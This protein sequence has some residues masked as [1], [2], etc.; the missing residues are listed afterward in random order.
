MTRPVRRGNPTTPM[1]QSPGA[2]LETEEQFDENVF[3][4]L[5]E[6]AGR[7]RTLVALDSETTRIDP[8]RGF[9]PFYGPR[10][11]MGSISFEDGPTEHNYAFPLRMREALLSLPERPRKREQS[12]A[13]TSALKAWA[14]VKS[15]DQPGTFDNQL[16][17]DLGLEIEVETV[18]N[19]RPEFV[20]GRLNALTEAGVVWVMKNVK[21]DVLMY[22]ADGME[23]IPVDQLEEVEFQSHLTEDKPWQK[24]KRVSHKLQ[25][26][27]VRHLDRAPDASNALEEWFTRMRIAKEL[28]DYS[29]VPARSILAPYAWQDTRDT[30]DLLHFFDRK[31]RRMDE[32]SQP[33]KK[34]FDLYRREVRVLWHL[35]YETITEGLPVDQEKADEVYS[36]YE[37]D[38][39]EKT[40]QLERLTGGREIDWGSNDEV[41]SYLYDSPADG[42]LGIPVPEGGWTSGGESGQ[43]KR[44]V[45]AYVLDKIDHPIVEQ[46]VAW[47]KADH[48]MN[49]FLAPI[50]RFNVGGFVHP[51]FHLTS[52]RTGRMSASH[53]NMQNRP[54]DKD[55]REM[56]VARP[57]YVL[58]AKDYDQIEMRIAAHFAYLV[59]KH[60]PTFWYESRF[61]GRS[62]MMRSHQEEAPM[63][64]GFNS[65][66][67]YDPHMKMVELSG[68]PRKRTES[69]EAT[70]K[71]GNF[72]IL[73]GS[74][75]GGLCRNFGWTQQFSRRV[76]KYWREAWPEIQ[77]LMNFVT[78]TIIEKGYVTNEF[79][80]RYYIDPDKAY[81]GLNYLIQGCAGDLM[82]RGLEALF[83][84]RWE[85]REEYEGPQPIYIDNVVHD[86]VL[87]E[88][89]EDLCTP[90]LVGRI[91]D[92]LTTHV[93]DDGSQ[94][95]NLPITAGAEVGYDWGHLEEY[96][97]REAA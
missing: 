5:I 38:R 34:L 65:D 64:E 19:L 95:F 67:K 26:L 88:V 18:E 23:R 96:E 15:A 53:P 79:G 90:Q 82:K 62:R 44:S 52:V 2:L 66:P 71:E 14:G 87:I 46:F 31:M 27:A 9:N 92:A 21:F 11:A 75:I 60:F 1:P 76:K 40:R 86:E 32:S 22:S 25:E 57:G 74:G 37:A 50:A 81:L 7:G 89:R 77:H 24:G 12:K 55:I 56:F 51:D 6:L 45:A 97:F 84:L 17:R 30:L 49:S 10:V 72:S 36:K 13:Y 59:C 41:A 91:N 16:W 78:K 47:R 35:T 85:L 73:Y 69:G 70:A 93:R 20:I 48:F 83:A 80:R 43:Q 54:K 8:A 39:D 33:G 28:R 94:V 58:C 29:A 63:W 68:L 61:R 4:P 3:E 42:G